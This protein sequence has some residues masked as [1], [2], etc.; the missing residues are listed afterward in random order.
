MIQWI[1]EAPSYARF[2][3]QVLKYLEA[4]LWL[5]EEIGSTSFKK[6]FFKKK[7]GNCFMRTNL[8]AL[9]SMSVSERL[10]LYCNKLLKKQSLS[11][12]INCG[13]TLTTDFSTRTVLS[14]CL[15]QEETI[16]RLGSSP[17]ITGFSFLKIPEASSFVGFNQNKNSKKVSTVFNNGIKIFSIINE[18]SYQVT[19]VTV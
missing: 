14:F 4:Q 5:V 19:R 8:K 10:R 11:E 16:S 3:I 18:I 17:G 7:R 9:I 15:F 6:Q 2:Q 13:F 12:N 1:E